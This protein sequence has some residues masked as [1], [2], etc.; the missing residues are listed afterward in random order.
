MKINNKN[1]LLYLVIF[2]ILLILFFYLISD[3]DAIVE[4]LKREI[5]DMETPPSQSTALVSKEG[6]TAGEPGLQWTVYTGYFADDVNFSRSLDKIWMSG[7][8]AKNLS[9]LKGMTNGAISDNTSQHVYTIELIG[10]F[11]PNVSTNWKFR[12]NSDDASYLWLGPSAVSGWTPSNAVVYNAGLHGAKTSEIKQDNNVQVLQLNAGQYYPIRIIMGENWGLYN[13]NVEW[14]FEIGNGNW[15]NWSSDGTNVLFPTNLAAPDQTMTN[16]GLTYKLY[17]GYMGGNESSPQPDDVNFASRSNPVSTG[18]SINL[19]NLSYMTNNF[20]IE[21]V[22]FTDADGI[23]SRWEGNSGNTN[24]HYFNIELFGYFKATQSG[25]WGFFTTSDDASY[26]W[27]GDVAKSGWTRDNAT[28]KNGGPHGMKT[29]VVDPDK[30]SSP[31][32]ETNLIAG[33]FYPIRIQFGERG[34]GY[35]FRAGWK[36]PGGTWTCN[37]S[38]NLYN[39]PSDAIA[40]PPNDHEYYVVV[41]QGYDP[42]PAPGLNLPSGT[43]CTVSHDCATRVCENNKCK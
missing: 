33:N 9:S 17:K 2:A 39:T 4:Q 7:I 21:N 12:T 6:F 31:P 38:N 42:G 13:L 14:C 43:Y 24:T 8:A 41:T 5:Y 40:E 30:N 23:P 10:F 35:G 26:L 11:R 1:Y 37:G 15:S 25:Y 22:R 19:H 27:I 28:V 3:K 34:G 18:I 20:V 36:P 16:K 29:V 32:P